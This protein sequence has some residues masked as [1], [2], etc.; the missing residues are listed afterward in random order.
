MGDIAKLHNQVL[1]WQNVSE[2]HFEIP[3]SF[4]REVYVQIIRKVLACVRHKAYKKVKKALAHGREKVS[5]DEMENIMTDINEKHQETYRT[6]ALEL[7]K[8]EVPHGE[9]PKRLM[10]KAYLV[11][12]TISGI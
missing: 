11:Y 4:T 12:S 1:V 6:K 7:Y 8:V 3:A 2:I 9:Q 5:N 10:Q